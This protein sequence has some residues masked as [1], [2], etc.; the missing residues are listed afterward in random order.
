MTVNVQTRSI[1]ASE[2]VVANLGE[3]GRRDGRDELRLKRSLLMQRDERIQ[4]A[5]DGGAL[6][7]T[8]AGRIESC[9][10]GTMK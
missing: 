7:R 2:R 10:G 9:G 6:I 5:A 4:R 8:V 3:A 1:G